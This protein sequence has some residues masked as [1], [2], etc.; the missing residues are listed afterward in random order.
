MECLKPHDSV[1][2]L[3][4]GT[5]FT[6]WAFGKQTQGFGEVI[7]NTAMTGYQEVLSDPSY[8]QQLVVMTYPHQG[9]Y[10]LNDQDEESRGGAK[11]AGFIV[12][13]QVKRPSN[14]TSKQSLH[15]YL[16]K[17]GVPGLSGV[18]TRKL[19]LHIRSKGAMRGLILSFEQK[20]ALGH[21]ASKVFKKYPSFLGRDLIKE[22][23]T[24]QPYWFSEAGSKTV[25]VLDF[26]VKLNLLR[27]LAARE[28]KVVVL[29]AASSVEDILKYKPDGVFLSNGP[30]DPA[31]AT[32]AIDSVRA[33]LG[34]KP[35]FGV[36]MGHQIL[37]LALG[38]KTF[39]MKFGHR[40]VNQPVLNIATKA[41]EISSHNHGF[42]VDPDSL[43]Q[44]VTITHRNL[45]DGTCEGLECKSQKAFSV[46]YHP[47]SA[48]G[49]HDSAYLFDRFIQML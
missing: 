39:K 33:L 36:C 48:P 41:V 4:D 45:N 38:G 31:E 28:A 35:V 18:D 21:D 10:G 42:A 44:E 3:E 5:E 16:E 7:F 26:G 13:E 37:G 32:Y 49:P 30:G 43:P 47:E 14:F 6:G 15:D 29:P 9:N 20:R 23:T 25:V 2:W 12:H 8:W 22:I 19:T 24:K 27:E 1:L 17:H 34:K 11:V 40:G 46:Q